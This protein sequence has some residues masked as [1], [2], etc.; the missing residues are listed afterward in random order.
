MQSVPAWEWLEKLDAKREQRYGTVERVIV[1]APQDG[2]DHPKGYKFCANCGTR[3]TYKVSLDG[4]NYY[5]QKKECQ[6][7]KANWWDRKHA[8]LA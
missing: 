6:K 7:A 3:S 5:C 1:D 2:V 8:S 4:S